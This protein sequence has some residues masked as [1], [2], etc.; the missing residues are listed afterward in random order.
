MNGRVKFVLNN[1][2]HYKFREH[3]LHKAEE[4]GSKVEI[5]TEEYTSQC[6]GHCGMLSD[7]YI[8]RVKICPI[9]KS[10]I[11]RDINGARNILLKNVHNF[12][13]TPRA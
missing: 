8:K 12:I 7:E 5:V 4:Y 2:S 6:C 13:A 3:L 11:N 1:L 10:K 9:C